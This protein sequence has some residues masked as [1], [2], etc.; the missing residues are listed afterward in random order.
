MTAERL[1]EIRDEVSRLVSE[2][3]QLR[4]PEYPDLYVQGWIVCL[5]WTHVELVQKDQAAA[6]VIA[7]PEQ[8]FA[9]SRGLADLASER[10][11]FRT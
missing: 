9:T 11:A 5:E 6:L 1:D 10:Y 4:Q 3:A 7:P 8:M 2:F